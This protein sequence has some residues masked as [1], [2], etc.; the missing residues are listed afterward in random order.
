MTSEIC[1]HR[2]NVDIER[3][4]VACV[5]FDH[6]QNIGRYVFGF[7]PVPL[8]P[9]LKL[10][11]FALNLDVQSIFWFSPGNVKLLDPT[12]A[13]EPTTFSFECMM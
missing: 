7:F 10:I 9:R 8:I 2:P 4:V 1:C 6:S 13:A 3:R 12:S 5:P 11:D